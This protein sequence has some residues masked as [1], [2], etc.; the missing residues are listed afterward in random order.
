MYL[1]ISERY[2]VIPTK[3][4]I[5]GAKFKRLAWTPAFRRGDVQHAM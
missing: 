2:F 1:A 5:Q 3:A 4:G